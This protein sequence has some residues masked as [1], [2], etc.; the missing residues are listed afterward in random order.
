MELISNGFYCRFNILLFAV[1]GIANAKFYITYQTPADCVKLS[2]GTATSLYF[3]TVQHK[4]MECPQ[5]ST[6]QTVSPDGAFCFML[7]HPL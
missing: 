6:A 5:P 3:N 2:D 4:C 1:F 7:F